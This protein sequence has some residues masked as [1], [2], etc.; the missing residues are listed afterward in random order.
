MI[1]TLSNSQPN[2]ISK[3]HN[4]LWIFGDQHRGQAMSCAGDPNVS[5]PNLDLLAL[6]GYRVTG[7]VS[8]FP[9]CCP[10]RGALLSGC[11]PHHSVPGHEYQLDPQKPTIATAFNQ[12]GYHTAYFGKWH[13]DGFHESQGR[14]AFHRIPRDR[15]GGFQQWLGY[16]NNNSQWDTW[17]HGGNQSEEIEPYRLPGFETDELT[18]L[19]I[20]YLKDRAQNPDNPFFGVLSVQPPHNPY[21]P[22]QEWMGTHHPRKLDLRPNVPLV[23]RIQ[24]QAR[25]ELAG[26]YG[27][28]EN[29]D[30]NVG[31]IIQTL[32]DTGLVENTWVIFFSDHGDMHGSHG[33][34]RKTTPYQEA[35]SVPMIISEPGRTNQF[36]NYQTRDC[37]INH[38]DLGPTSLGFCGIPVP[39]WMEGTDYSGLFTPN[40]L[41]QEYPSSAYLQCV[42]PPKH[43]D[44]VDKP[45][46]GVITL[47][48]WKYVC[49]PNQDWLMFNLKEDPYEQV[50]LAHNVRYKAQRDRL[51]A[52]TLGWVEKTG[53]QFQVPRD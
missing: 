51:R 34:F 33:Q 22:P 17:V 28:I 30:W 41:T 49:F 26:Y 5:T 20:S 42:I 3:N 32:R 53:D 12:A 52:E 1:K 6:E 38:V 2:T 39:D 4:I 15:R 16:E 27:L 43:R 45:W 36:Q 11:Y 46:R 40:P 18:N 8:G 31:R 21:T 37:L 10:Y 29:W 9:L 50:N 24:D 19:L 14:A 13:V 48:R 23:E 44:S 47:D 25:L 35:I 7:G